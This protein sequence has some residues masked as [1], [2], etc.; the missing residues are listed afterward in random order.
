MANESST[1][2]RVYPFPAVS[3][4]VIAKLNSPFLSLT[5]LY[6]NSPALRADFYVKE[7]FNT[8]ALEGLKSV[9]DQL[10][11]LS[12]SRMPIS[13]KE[14]SVIG[15]FNNLEKLNLNF[16]NV[17]SDLKP[18]NSLTHLKSLSL[19]GTGV[20][21]KALA[22][23][24]LPEL[25]ELFVWNTTISEVDRATINSKLSNV[26]IVWTTISDDQP[27]QLSMPL[28]DQEDVFKRDQ[29]LVLRHPMPG[30]TIRYTLDGS[31][32]DSIHGEDY[33]APISLHGTARLKAYAFKEGWLKS[34]VLEKI[35]FTEGF[36]P[37]AAKLLAKP[38]PQYP[39]EGAQSLMDGRKGNADLFKEPSWLGFR[40][41]A[42]EAEFDFNRDK[43]VLTSIAISYGRNIGGYIFPPAEVQKTKCPC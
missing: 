33:K 36:K 25:H 30:V 12:L 32:P 27:I 3:E 43:P 6:R 15:K 11:E 17:S 42:F 29:P 2:E 16:T 35:C 14:L 31:D 9:K 28:L 10:V 18:L 39:G 41:N 22:E 34:D 5:P 7:A 4:D 21:T 40:N 19:S 1:K 13:D 37:T 24:S 26:S 23:L 8:E 38:D 20:T